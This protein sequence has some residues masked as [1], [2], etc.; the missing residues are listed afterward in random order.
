MSPTLIAKPAQV[1][2]KDLAS[3][4]AD[5]SFL[6]ERLNCDRF[7]VDSPQ[8]N[9]AE[10]EQR[11][12]HEVAQLR[13]DRW[14][15]NV[16]QEN[17]LEILQKR[18]QWEGLKLDDIYPRLGKV[19]LA[20][21]AS[22]PKWAQTLGQIIETAATYNCETQPLSVIDA[23][24]SIPFED[25][26]LPAI[27]VARKNLLTHLG[28]TELTADNLPLSILSEKA[29]ITLERSLL[30]RL[31]LISAKTLD[32]E[33]SKIRPF[34]QNLLN[35]LG[36]EETK[37]DST[38]KYHQF[39]SR[40]LEDG[41]LSFFQQYPVLGRLIAVAVDLWVA[42][43][44]E[45]IQRLANDQGKIQQVFSQKQSDLGKVCAIKTSLSDPHNQGRTVILLTFESGLKLVY[46]P[47]DLGLELAWNQL[48]IWCNRNSQL[49]DIKVI[50]VFNRDGYGWVE[51]VEH[52]PCSEQSAIARFYQRAGMLMC[53]V[54]VLRGTDCHYEN[55]I[56]NGE[57]L[58]LIDMESLLH[59]DSKIMEDSP[60]AEAFETESVQLF[61]DSV[62]RTGLLPRW[63]F[64]PDQRVAY[65]ISGLGSISPQ[66]TS[67][68]VKR[69]QAVN[70][71]NMHLRSENITMPVQK[72]MPLWGEK[73]QSPN[74]YQDQIL[75]GFEQMYHFLME[76]QTQ[77]L[78]ADSP[79]AQLQQQ[80]V[81]FI[82]R[83]TRIYFTILKNAWA[84]DYLKNG[85]DYSIELES[86]SRAFVVAEQ[87]PDAWPIL[88]AEL[89]AMEQLDIPFF[90]ANTSSD[91]LKLNN[92]PA[93]AQYFKQS[94]YQQVLEK[95]Q[96]LDQIDLAQQVAIIQGA[97]SARVAQSSTTESYSWQE[98]EPP[99]LTQEQLIQA[100]LAIAFELE[101]RA[102]QDAD[103]SL[104]WIGLGFV[105]QAEHF[106][107]QVLNNSLYDGR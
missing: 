68:K 24:E 60:E 95:F 80:R 104:N 21:E 105:P 70:T 96:N 98:D 5:A 49:L 63:D 93:I 23:E 34:G 30:Q 46:K 27:E 58:V 15:Q 71:D 56:A 51:Y 84:P 52:L 44:G 33:F 76:H 57:H 97:F 64:G 16:A 17:K 94:S 50:K 82:F 61:W 42:A 45:F 13:C 4:V 8:I 89:Q 79:L 38:S 83:A 53:L 25:L 100:A 9:Q 99:L 107:L 29:Y 62:L 26:W 35:L 6:W 103:G 43:T 47:K 19:K 55:L 101:A 41:L 91:A 10:L 87:Q 85:V 67:R 22:L 54:Y 2:E 72:N 14:R 90:T 73:T 74:D 1:T 77:L 88:R 32:F 75:V 11:C 12:D 86:L 69:W 81:R 36:I 102:L 31:S 66:Q 37:E 106:Q 78:A 48:L 3:I 40:F 65:D 92:I 7:I 28:V 59:H 39:V 20:A 18:L